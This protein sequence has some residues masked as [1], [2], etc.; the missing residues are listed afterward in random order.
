MTA[1]PGSFRSVREGPRTAP[2]SPV[3]V[4]HA[5]GTSP[6]ASRASG[7][8]A[9]ARG[10]PQGRWMGRFRKSRQPQA[11]RNQA[12]S[13][14]R[15]SPAGSEATSGARR[16]LPRRR[17]PADRPR[18]RHEPCGARARRTI[19]KTRQDGS[20]G[21]V[22][23][24]EAATMPHERKEPQKGLCGPNSTRLCNRTGGS[25]GGRQKRVAVATWWVAVGRNVGGA[26]ADAPGPVASRHLGSR[27][28]STTSRRVLLA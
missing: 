2:G 24:G 7:R 4:R 19:T 16:I 25:G 12:S 1:Y 22:R 18:A 6:E 26:P 15:C 28:S 17:S 11:R 10:E 9:G 14:V 8:A 27:K 5:W 21:I 23:R 13:C 20:E 3:G